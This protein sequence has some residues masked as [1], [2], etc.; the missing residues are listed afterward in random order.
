MILAK[1]EDCYIFVKAIFSALTYSMN[2]VPLSH[3]FL[4]N[5]DLKNN[6]NNLFITNLAVD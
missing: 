4:T 3:Q 2:H 1:I 6:T 5:F